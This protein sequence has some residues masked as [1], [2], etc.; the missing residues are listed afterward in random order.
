MKTKEEIAA[1]EA[2]AETAR[3]EAEAA[4]KTAAEEAAKNEKS[5][6]DAAAFA[7][8]Q[9]DLAKSKKEAADVKAQLIKIEEDKLR[10]NK[11]WEEISKRKE[12]EAEEANKR[13]ELATKTLNQDKKLSEIRSEAQRLG[14]SQ[15]GLKDLDLLD[16]PEVETETSESGKI[17]VHGAKEAVESLK[18]TRPHWFESKTPSI[19]PHGPTTRRAPGDGSV[20]MDDVL[21]LKAEWEKTRTPQSKKAYDEAHIKYRTSK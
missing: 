11:N 10:A 21:K 9:A 17:I 12:R 2:A 1:E 7:R 6:K 4:E 16:F 3:L 15:Q 13:A 19:N 5:G 20:T 18:A 8:M 14:I